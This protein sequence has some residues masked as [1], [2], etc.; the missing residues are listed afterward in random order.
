MN[1]RAT[2]TQLLHR[3]VAAL[4]RSEALQ[5][6]TLAE[7]RRERRGPGE[8]TDALASIVEA[9]WERFGDSPWSV[10]D[11]RA[12][13]LIPEGDTLRIGQRLGQLQREGGLI[14]D[15]RLGSLDRPDR[16]GKTWFLKSSALRC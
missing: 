8:P 10:A 16:N 9:A 15:L 14:G 5:A 11:L 13:R 6:A 3:A 4:E 12:A 1:D 7:L 2:L